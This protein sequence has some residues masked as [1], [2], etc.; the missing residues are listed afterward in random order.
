MSQ[1][2]LALGAHITDKGQL[3]PQGFLSVP[4]H[5]TRTGVFI[6][7][8]NDGSIIRELRHPDDVFDQ[9]SLDS[10]RMAPLTDDHPEEFVTPENF[11]KYSV[12]YIDSQIT[13]DG[14]LVSG[15]AVVAAQSAIKKVDMGKKELSCGYLADLVEES[16]VYNGER[17]DV[18]QKNIRYNHVAIVDKGR[19]GSAVRLRLDAEDAI[20]I[21]DNGENHNGG[22]NTMKKIKIDGKEFEVS[23]E[24]AAAFEKKQ[25]DEAEEKKKLEDAKIAAEEEAKKAKKDHADAEASIV[26]IKSELETTKGKLDAAEEKVKQ[27]ADG[28]S[29]AKIDEA[30]KARVAVEKV[31]V[32]VIGK[33]AKFDGKSNLDIMKEVIIKNS[34]KTD[35]KDKSEEYVKARFDS[36]TEDLDGKTERRNQFANKFEDKRADADFDSKAAREKAHKDSTEEWKQPLATVK[37]EV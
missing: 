1:R 2:R 20:E 28:L 15:L 29:Q 23:D 3:T 6:Y 13:N 30:V 9:T 21:E 34:P 5:F 19:A 18:R 26:T 32:E 25:A 36:I 22:K 12:G 35:L 16:G 24:A 27:H 11:Q 10:L 31:A 7:R 33:E 17:Y 8:R 4:A 37:K 14:K